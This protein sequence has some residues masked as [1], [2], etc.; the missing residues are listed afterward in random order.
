[1]QYFLELEISNLSAE[2]AALAIIEHIKSTGK[3]I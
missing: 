2:V 1:M 3:F